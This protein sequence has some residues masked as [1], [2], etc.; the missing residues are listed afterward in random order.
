M[1]ALLV[2]SAATLLYVLRDL[3]PALAWSAYA[4]LDLRWLAVCVAILAT[5]QLLRAARMHWILAPRSRPG[6]GR[7]LAITAI[8][9][10][11]ITTLPLRLG[12]AARPW[13]LA[14]EGVSVAEGTG[15]VVVERTFDLLA[16]IGLLLAATLLVEQPSGAL[17][18]PGGVD[19]VSA[20]TRSVGAVVATAL[21]A[22][23]ALLLGGERVASILRRV[24]GVGEPA[25]DFVLRMRAAL[26]GLSRSPARLLAVAAVSA[27][28][29]LA[30]VATA[31]AMLWA[32]PGLP[33]SPALALTLATAV[34]AGTLVLP[35]PG[36]FG[37]FELSAQAVLVLWSVE[38]GHAASFAIAWHLLVFLFT[39]GV[40]WVFAALLGVSVRE[41]IARPEPSEAS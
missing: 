40:G 31:W 26:R 1:A 7:Q 35:T 30:T 27:A 3:D 29:W 17:A 13:L 36:F 39:F 25:A 8:G 41:A 9:F 32:Y 34:I 10:M 15:A 33:R 24:P 38:R 11:A 20:A 2:V 6:F 23:L 4:T 16:L 22:L 37:P 12:E 21:A 18:L 28:V 19:V 5:Q 14:R